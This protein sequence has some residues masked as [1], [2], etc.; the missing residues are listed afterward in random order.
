MYNR[1]T[2]VVFPGKRCLPG[3]K[4]EYDLTQAKGGMDGKGHFGQKNQ[5]VQ[6]ACNRREQGI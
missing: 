4:K 6:M 2:N 5:H 3:A 1:E